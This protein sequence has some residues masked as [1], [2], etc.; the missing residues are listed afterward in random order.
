MKHFKRY[1]TYCNTLIK[2]IKITLK[3]LIFS[4]LKCFKCFD[5]I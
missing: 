2:T 4:I 1:N 3:T 5:I